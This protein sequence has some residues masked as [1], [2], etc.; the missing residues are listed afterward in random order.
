MVAPTWDPKYVSSRT[1]S[2]LW[3]SGYRK[4]QKYETIS[5]LS[6]IIF[7]VPSSSSKTSIGTIDTLLLLA[8]KVLILWRSGGWASSVKKSGLEGVSF[9]ISNAH[10]AF[11]QKWEGPIVMRRTCF[12]LL[13]LGGSHRICPE[14]LQVVTSFFTV[15]KRGLDQNLDFVGIRSSFGKLLILVV[16]PK[17]RFCK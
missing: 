4:G 7:S 17:L 11:S 15:L 6:C 2:S 9:S 14:E 10:L 16:A 12:V 1:I 5:L 13:K 8:S 3:A